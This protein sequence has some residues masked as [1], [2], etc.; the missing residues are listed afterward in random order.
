MIETCYKVVYDNLLIHKKPTKIPTPKCVFSIHCDNPTGHVMQLLDEMQ[1]QNVFDFGDYTYFNVDRKRNKYKFSYFKDVEK[2]TCKPS[3]F[4]IVV[5]PSMTT[6]EYTEEFYN[7]I[8]TKQPFIVY[9]PAY[10]HKHLVLQRYQL[11]D[12]IFNYEFDKEHNLQKRKELFVQELVKLKKYKNLDN[13]NKT[14]YKKATYNCKHMLGFLDEMPYE[15]L[16]KLQKF[17]KLL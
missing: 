12:E 6:A 5:L 9:G 8:Y 3:L 11:Y 15:N 4:R 1:K 10:T 7:T 2:T 17:R 16:N 13:L 14:L